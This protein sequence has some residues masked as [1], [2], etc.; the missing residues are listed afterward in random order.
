MMENRLLLYSWKKHV[1]VKITLNDSK[2][3]NHYDTYITTVENISAEP[4]IEIID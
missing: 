1:V 2:E 4:D 3:Y